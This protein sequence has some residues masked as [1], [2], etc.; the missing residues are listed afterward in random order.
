M[1]HLPKYTSHRNVWAIYNY[2]R[3]H[4]STSAVSVSLPQKIQPLCFLLLLRYRIILA[5]LADKFVNRL[6]KVH[7][8]AGNAAVNHP[9]VL[10]EVRIFSIP[11]CGDEAE[12]FPSAYIRRLC[13]A[14]VFVA[15]C[16][17]GFDDAMRFLPVIFQ[18]LAVFVGRRGAHDN[19]AVRAG[20]LIYI[21]HVP[22]V[23]RAIIDFATSANTGQAVYE[24]GLIIVCCLHLYLHP[25][26]RYTLA[27]LVLWYGLAHC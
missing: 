21:T 11:D 13:S 18:P 23:D 1:V 4:S 3:K 14:F 24:H 20:K 27:M 2:C 22:D 26:S 9:I 7:V 12:I 15:L 25:S 19:A 6:I 10:P 5:Q 8:L 17:Q 16:C